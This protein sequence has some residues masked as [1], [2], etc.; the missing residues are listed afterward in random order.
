M[1][2]ETS[3]EGQALPPSP[4]RRS[5]RISSGPGSDLVVLLVAQ[6]F[7]SG[8]EATCKM[9]D[10]LSVV[11]VVLE[12]KESER[13]ALI[14]NPSLEQHKSQYVPDRVDYETV[15]SGESRDI[16]VIPKESPKFL[17]PRKS[18]L[19]Q[20]ST[21]PSTDNT[22]EKENVSNAGLES[23]IEDMLPELSPWKVFIPEIWCCDH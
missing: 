22:Q 18:V 1:R 2:I 15:L 10:D 23:S 12:K 19:K 9:L 7:E 4:S 6:S 16:M 17:K 20:S 14:D 8:N 11:E 3:R 5:I 21:I 13:A